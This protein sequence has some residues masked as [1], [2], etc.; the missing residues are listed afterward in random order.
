MILEQSLEWQTTLYTVFVDFQKAFVS[1]DREVIWKLMPHYGFP[2]KIVNIIKQF[3]QDATCQVIH[4]GMLTGPFSV[5]TGVCQGCILSPTTGIQWTLTNQLEDLDFADDIS[6]L[7]HRF[8]DAQQKLNNVATEAAKT[9][10]NIN[11]KKTEIMRVN[12]A[13]NNPIQLQ[14]ED[15]KEVGKFGYL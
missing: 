2:A 12:N 1:V 9:G 7:S 15:I 6:V 8:Q 10:L 14:Q 5:E 11:T 3:Y 13:Q 4:D